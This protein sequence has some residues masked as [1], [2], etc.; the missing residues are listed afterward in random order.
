M[1]TKEKEQEQL[2][3]EKVYRI[4]KKVLTDFGVDMFGGVIVDDEMGDT[5]QESPTLQKEEE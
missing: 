2:R 5:P 3:E 1:D 4:L